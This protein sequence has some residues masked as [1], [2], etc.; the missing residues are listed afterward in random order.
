MK[1]KNLACIYSFSHESSDLDNSSSFNL[2]PTYIGHTQ[3]VF[4]RLKDH[5]LTS[6]SAHRYAGRGLLYPYA[7]K[8][9]GIDKLNFSVKFCF[10]NYIYLFT[11]MYGSPSPEFK[12]ILKSFTEFKCA[13]YEQSLISYY[14][15]NLNT[16]NIINFTFNNW[17][18]GYK[19]AEFISFFETELPIGNGK[20]LYKRLFNL[21]KNR[22]NFELY[23]ELCKYKNIKTPFATQSDLEWLVGFIE[24]RC[25]GLNRFDTE[26]LMLSSKNLKFL[27]YISDMLNL[28]VKPN[29]NG[30]KNAYQLKFANNLDSEI[31][32]S[33]LQNNIITSSF[34]DLFN[35]FESKF[36]FVD[37]ITTVNSNIIPSLKDA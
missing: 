15:P 24:K 8:V 28:I 1:Y 13:I 6:I 32:F 33:I 11:N 22:F 20:D 3:D 9:G 26:S 14:Q 10:P 31:I 4:T 29:L 23:Y 16:S 7:L 21:K 19:K 18:I 2:V 34:L 5:Y 17:S 25:T 35:T 37:S 36:N 12:Y 30:S 27:K